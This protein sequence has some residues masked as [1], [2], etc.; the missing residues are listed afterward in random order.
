[1][2]NR[3]RGSFPFPFPTP[4]SKR[5]PSRRTSA[6]C[7]S[8]KVLKYRPTSDCIPRPAMA[9]TPNIIGSPCRVHRLTTAAF[10]ISP[11]HWASLCCL[12]VRTRTQTGANSPGNLAF[13]LR[14]LSYGG[15]GVCLAS[16]RPGVAL[17]KTGFRQNL[18]I[19]PS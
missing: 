1:M 9:N 3:V 17:A 8:L 12:P 6:L 5:V 7:G 10:T 19:P 11:E 2:S 13:R 4:H 15:T 14:S 18:T 16:R